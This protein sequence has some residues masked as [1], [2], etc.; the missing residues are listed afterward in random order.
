MVSKHVLFII[1]N[2]LTCINKN[3]ACVRSDTRC[4]KNRKCINDKNPLNQLQKT[5]SCK[6][7]KN[8]Q[9]PNSRQSE[10][11]GIGLGTMDCPKTWV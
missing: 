3:Y 9:Y 11:I 6:T 2:I 7:V 1:K 10:C 8:C 4:G 5:C